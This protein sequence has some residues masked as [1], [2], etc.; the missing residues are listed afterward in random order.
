LLT[1]L[2]GFV[3]QKVLGGADSGFLYDMDN[4]GDMDIVAIAEGIT[5]WYELVDPDECA[6]YPKE[7]KNSENFKIILETTSIKSKKIL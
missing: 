4:D 2:D 7:K 3:A 5:V 6:V 1:L